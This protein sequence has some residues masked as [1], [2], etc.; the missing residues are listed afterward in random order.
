M[1][2]I[3]TTTLTTTTRM[4]S[5]TSTTA[6]TTQNVPSWHTDYK[7]CW[8]AGGTWMFRAI[9]SCVCVCVRCLVCTFDAHW[10]KKC[11]PS[12]QCRGN[13]SSDIKVSHP[14]ATDEATTKIKQNVHS[15]WRTDIGR[16]STRTLPSVAVCECVCHLN[17]DYIVIA[18][19]FILFAARFFLNNCTLSSYNT[20]FCSTCFIDIY[21][22]TRE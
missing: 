19:D 2:N 20:S 10:I 12:P 4:T 6:T 17:F 3:A 5:T 15:H 13:S 16:K 7:K 21:T 14:K 11:M 1:C 18:F 22:F 9:L 8:H